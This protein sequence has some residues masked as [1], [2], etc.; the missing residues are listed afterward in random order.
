M[1]V[2]IFDINLFESLD[3][4]MGVAS[5]IKAPPRRIPNKGDHI[6]S[7]IATMLPNICH[8]NSFDHDL[9]PFLLNPLESKVSYIICH[10]TF[11]TV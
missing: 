6:Y 9:I 4:L 2:L 10:Q 8:I 7:P 5:P 1:N 11:P 3:P